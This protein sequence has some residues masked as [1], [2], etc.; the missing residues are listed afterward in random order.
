[1]QDSAGLR[2]AI[3]TEAARLLLRRKERDYAAARIRAS[4]WLSR[5]RVGRDEMP[6]RDE[7][8]EQIYVLAGLESAE[9]QH[10][11]LTELRYVALE[12]GERLA[13][14]APR[15]VGPVVDGPVTPGVEIHV[16]LPA[17]HEDAAFA[18]LR[19]TAEATDLDDH[20]PGLLRLR[21]RR[22]PCRLV[23]VDGLQAR[24]AKR[25]ESTSPEDSTP[26]EP[27]TSLP[28]ASRSGLVEDPIGP[29]QEPD[30][31]DL[32][33]LAALLDRDDEAADDDVP[34]GDPAF[35][36][37]VFRMLLARLEDVRLDPDRHPEGD[38]LYHSLQVF[39]LGR[40]E[41][42][43]DEEF[44]L[45]CL[46]HDV[47]LAIDPRHRTEAAVESLSGLVTERTLFL[48]ENLPRMEEALR[49]GSIPRSLRRS[50]HYDDLLLL[51][52]CNQ[53]GRVAGATTCDADEALAYVAGLETAWDDA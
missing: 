47:G 19:E 22:R 7:I 18:A 36:F 33:A 32:A 52:R 24:S 49:G 2:A 27:E 13:P 26:E 41:R 25:R 5:R 48:V 39:E 31:L 35:A 44:L 34:L 21:F 9:H 12:L 40:A 6:S 16:L 23:F 30:G 53:A 14:F 29:D 38:A 17:E 43:W 50:E 1:M 8:E 15:F 20:E 11:R 28:V 10:A 51:A 3:A 4:R 37:D 46:L 45:A 42:A